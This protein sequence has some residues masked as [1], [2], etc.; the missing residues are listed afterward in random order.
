MKYMAET[1]KCDEFK[2]N[3]EF[4]QVISKDWT[5]YCDDELQSYYYHNNTTGEATWIEPS[6]TETSN[7]EEKIIERVNK[8]EE[9]GKKEEETSGGKRK[10]TKKRK[11]GG[12]S[13][14]RKV[15]GKSKK[16]GSRKR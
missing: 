16:R 10:N 11:V 2:S 9:G 13:K 4:G 15:G 5:K 7:F 3:N 14:K 1:K 8:L 6:K 12:K